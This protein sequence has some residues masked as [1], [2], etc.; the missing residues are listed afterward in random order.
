MRSVP[1]S[2]AREYELVS[3]LFLDVVSFSPLLTD[4]QV[5]VIEQLTAIVKGTVQFQKATKL[6]PIPTGD[7]MALVFLRDPTLPVQCA[8]EIAKAL[9]KQNLPIKLRMGINAG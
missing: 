7:G 5:A 4:Q 9:P 6:V 1:E 3:V 2:P 8:L